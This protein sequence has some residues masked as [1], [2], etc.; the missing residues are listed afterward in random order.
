MEESKGEVNAEMHPGLYRQVAGERD[1]L[2]EQ[3][4]ELILQLSRK[5]EEIRECRKMLD[6]LILFSVGMLRQLSTGEERVSKPFT[7][8]APAERHSSGVFSAV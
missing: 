8:S 7:S 3:R 5:D 1:F 4:A 6:S 2:R